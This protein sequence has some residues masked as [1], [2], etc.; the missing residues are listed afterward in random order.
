MIFNFLPII[1]LDGS[2]I[3]STILNKFFSYHLAYKIDLILSLF[4]IILY[5][6]GN[7]WY[8]LN[9]YL[10]VILFIYKTYEACK[11]YPYLYY[12]FLLERYLHNYHFKYLSTKKGDLK[13][14]KKDTYQYFKENTKIVSEKQK[15]KEFFFN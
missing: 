3:L 13:I 12:R 11:N 10:M 4:F 2:M 5:L 6:V 15:L 1:P 7:Y 14:L 9:N 8:A